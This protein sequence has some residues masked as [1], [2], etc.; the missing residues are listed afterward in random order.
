MYAP[1]DLFSKSLAYATKIG[2][3]IYI[4]SSKYGLIALESVIEPYEYTIINQPRKVQREWVQKIITAFKDLPHLEEIREIVILAG[5]DYY[6]DLLSFFQSLNFKI[7][8][9]LKG[10]GSGMRKHHLLELIAEKG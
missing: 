5:E 9:P 3:R 10:L 2:G 8:L 1:S 7:I 4:L 6:R